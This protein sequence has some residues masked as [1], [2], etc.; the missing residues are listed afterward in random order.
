MELSQG[1][2][3][4]INEQQQRSSC[5]T[6]SYLE[7]AR[8]F[9]LSNYQLY[10]PYGIISGFGLVTLLGLFKLASYPSPTVTSTPPTP[11]SIGQNVLDVDLLRN[12]TFKD[13]KYYQFLQSL[14]QL[15]ESS[16][17]SNHHQ[18]YNNHYTEGFKFIILSMMLCQWIVIGCL[19]SKLTK[20]M[21]KTSQDI[22]S[23][24]GLLS[25]VQKFLD[26]ETQ[27]LSDALDELDG[28]LR[29][30]ID[31]L[32]DTQKNEVAKISLSIG[33]I[34]NEIYK[35]RQ[36]S[37]LNNNY[38]TGFHPTGGNNPPPSPNIPFY[39]FYPTKYPNSNN[40][41]N[42][43]TRNIL[44]TDYGSFDLSTKEGR[45]KW[46]RTM[47]MAQSANNNNNNNDN[48]NKTTITANNNT[49]TAI[50]PT[51]L[52]LNKPEFYQE[53]NS[54]PPKQSQQPI[55]PL[56]SNEL[57]Q[58]LEEGE[59]KQYRRLFIPG[60][61]WMSAKRLQEESQLL[62]KAEHEAAAAAAVVASS[63]R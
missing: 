61:G 24:L 62:E 63:S 2:P 40:N 25:D 42:K 47:Q 34:W 7:W 11:A 20:G 5:T 60:R 56:T 44:K 43:N 28:D 1:T 10:I 21:N 49:T 17:P 48:D 59:K 26:G 15:I 23:Q 8:E 22:C 55:V 36:E 31:E 57:K 33:S 37:K 9:I 27:G 4:P 52:S 3:P 38:L 41:K 12:V 19:A 54:S 18:M 45:D 30:A 58:K 14:N 46:I 13:G 39:D 6:N 32:N 16:T 29:S 53:N 35:M 51:Q 50:K